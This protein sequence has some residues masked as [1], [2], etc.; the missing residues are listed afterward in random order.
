MQGICLAFFP[1]P[2]GSEP[3]EE[4][5]PNPQPPLSTE[6]EA[7]ERGQE[8]GEGERGKPQGG[9]GVRGEA[10]AEETEGERQE[11]QGGEWQPE[12]CEEK[13]QL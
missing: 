11:L 2:Q 8:E 1:L 4:A 3:P 12:V 9:G 5:F 7:G 10:E 13:Q 6:G